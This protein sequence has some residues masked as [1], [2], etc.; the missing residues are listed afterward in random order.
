MIEFLTLKDINSSHF[1]EMMEI[2]LNS[3]PENERHPDKIIANRIASGKE[4][5]YIG[6]QTS[7]VVFM[8]LLWPLNGTDFILIDYLATKKENRQSGLAKSFINYI[9]QKSIKDSKNLILEVED[10][11]FGTNTNEREKRITFYRK[12]GFKQFADIKY[13]L[14]PLQGDQ[15]TQM[16]LMVFQ[17]F[18]SEFIDGKQAIELISRIYSELYGISKD[19]QLLKQIKDTINEQVR[20]I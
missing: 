18:P 3:F 17:S 16:L 11:K 2:Y 12:L 7:K 9:K 14:P 4:I 1:K 20:I 8:A 13:I 5:C 15:E 10:P 19:S 6:V